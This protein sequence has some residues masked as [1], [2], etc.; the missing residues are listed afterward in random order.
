MSDSSAEK[1]SDPYY[2]ESTPLLVEFTTGE[3][4]RQ[5]SFP[6]RRNRPQFEEKSN[7][8]FD[9]AMTTIQN[10]AGRV[11]SAVQKIES[12]PN[13][14]EIEFGIKFDAEVG[15]IVAKASMEASLNATLTWDQPE[16]T[17]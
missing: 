13:H 11:N 7:K 2:E 3:G 6:F 8:A 17:R 9:K 10:V 14:V 1:K 16:T 12:R 4:L 5:V 15:V